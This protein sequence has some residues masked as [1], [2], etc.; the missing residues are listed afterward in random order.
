MN[1][2]S[3]N[4]NQC[5]QLMPHLMILKTKRLGQWPLPL[6]WVIHLILKD[7]HHSIR[8]ICRSETVVYYLIVLIVVMTLWILRPLLGN[9]ILT[10]VHRIASIIKMTPILDSFGWEETQINSIIFNQLLQMNDN[11]LNIWKTL[12]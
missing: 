10:R 8:P 11:W 1:W 4:P 9:T 5:L 12:R 6:K 3:K 7:I 2:V